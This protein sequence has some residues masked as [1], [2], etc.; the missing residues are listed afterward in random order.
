MVQVDPVLVAIVLVLLLVVFAIFL[1]IRR[2]VTEFTQ[3]MRE[4]NR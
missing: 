1:L 4:G 2:T 3:G